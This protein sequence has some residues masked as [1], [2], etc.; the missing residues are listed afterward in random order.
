MSQHTICSYESLNSH[1]NAH[2]YDTSDARCPHFGL[3][4][5]LH[6]YIVYA[7]C[8]G[9]GK[10]AHMRGIALIFSLFMDVI[11]IVSCTVPFTLCVVLISR[12]A[13]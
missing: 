13:H 12:Q 6:P 8:E 4:L 1:V 7:S 2:A 11:S 3:S 10:S 5:N 9:S